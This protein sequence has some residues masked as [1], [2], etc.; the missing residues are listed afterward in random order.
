MRQEFMNKLSFFFINER[1]KL[2][3]KLFAQPILF[4]INLSKRKIVSTTIFYSLEM[5]YWVEKKYNHNILNN[6]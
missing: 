3:L 6:H 1:K 5:K 2:F 4:V